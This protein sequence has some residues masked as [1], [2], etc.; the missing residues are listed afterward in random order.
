MVKVE[1]MVKVVGEEGKKRLEGWRSGR[2]GAPTLLF[3]LSS[4]VVGAITP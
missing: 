2:L 3:F 1:L 4:I